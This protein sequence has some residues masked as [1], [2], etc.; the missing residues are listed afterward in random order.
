MKWSPLQHLL[1][2]GGKFRKP[3]KTET[4]RSQRGFRDGD[5]IITE[6]MFSLAW[7]VPTSLSEPVSK[8]GLLGSTS[9]SYRIYS[10]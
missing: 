9:T 2:A 7:S 5:F 6:V 8:N 3:S 4:D 10:L 1:V